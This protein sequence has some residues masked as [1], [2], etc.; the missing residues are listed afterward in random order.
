MFRAEIAYSLL[1]VSRERHEEFL[2]RLASS[3]PFENGII[4][5][6]A[7]FVHPGN[8]VYQ[9]RAAQTSSLSC[10]FHTI[11]DVLTKRTQTKQKISCE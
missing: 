8:S 9:A 5:M 11:I 7:C 10:F 2:L 3:T 6:L 4:G 1:N